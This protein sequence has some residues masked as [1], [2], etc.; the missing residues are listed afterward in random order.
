MQILMNTP[1]K[2]ER[3]EKGKALRKGM[4]ILMNTPLKEESDEKGK[5]LSC[6]RIQGSRR[7]LS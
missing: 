5:E 3:D 2:E 4:Q 1:L 6:K 7:R